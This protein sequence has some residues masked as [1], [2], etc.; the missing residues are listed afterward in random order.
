[1][2]KTPHKLNANGPRKKL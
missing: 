1:M 2:E